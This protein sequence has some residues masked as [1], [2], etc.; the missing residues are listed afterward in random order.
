MGLVKRRKQ[1]KPEQVNSMRRDYLS[2]P[3]FT[4]EYIAD[5]YDRSLNLVQRILE[6][7]LHFDP[8]Y[9]K[10]NNRKGGGTKR[11]VYLP[12]HIEEERLSIPMPTTAHRA[13]GHNRTINRFK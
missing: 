3:Q 5:K 10:P 4:I 11:S 9:I 6:N 13:R 2:N 7:K 12:E 8:D 1:L